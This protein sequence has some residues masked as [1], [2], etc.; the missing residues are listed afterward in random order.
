MQIKTDTFIWKTGLNFKIS[1][2]GSK[3]VGRER[4][5]GLEV[6]YVNPRKSNSLKSTF[7][8]LSSLTCV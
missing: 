3:A 5:Y 6:E 7:L 8:Q 4:L 2:E 1:E